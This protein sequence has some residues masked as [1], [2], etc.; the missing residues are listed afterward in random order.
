V[1]SRQVAKDLAGWAE[2]LYRAW[3]GQVHGGDGRRVKD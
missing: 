1:P 3:A 2:V